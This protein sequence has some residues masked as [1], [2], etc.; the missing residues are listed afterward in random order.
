MFHQ[1]DHRFGDYRDQPID[2]LGTSL[3]KASQARL[4]IDSYRVLPRYWVERNETRIRTVR[5]PKPLLQA[6]VANNSDVAEAL[7]LT[8]VIGHYLAR[9]DA[10]EAEL[11]LN[12]ENDC[13]ASVAP[14]FRTKAA[15]SQV[16]VEYP[17]N[18][19]ELS[20]ITA[21]EPALMRLNFLLEIRFPEWFLGWRDICRNTDERT[22]IFSC[23]PR[24]AVGHTAPLIRGA[25]FSARKALNLQSCLSS[26]A[27]D[28]IARQKIGG[29]HLTYG[30]LMQFP[31]PAPGTF[32]EVASWSGLSVSDWVYGRAL[33]LT[34][35]ASDLQPFAEELGYHG[36]PFR[37]DDDRRFLLRCELDAAFFHLYGIERTDVDYIM[38]TFPIVRRKDE[39]AHGE[40]RTKRV[41]LEIYDEMAEAA[42]TGTPY[43]TRLDP[44]PADPRVAHPPRAREPA[45]A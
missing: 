41:I 22:V 35:T 8:W 4:I 43:Q 12:E 15:A 45:E 26:Y 39:A 19:G 27:L 16:A 33:E 31:V 30:Y 29:T 11:L 32:E 28:Y 6:Y 10:A 3:P 20:I 37:W 21:S 9:G 18:E 44:P 36:R 17:L 38:D 7:L 14:A 42:H 1:F 40:Y 2:S 24:V 5:L 23:L 34:Y 25:E 13:W